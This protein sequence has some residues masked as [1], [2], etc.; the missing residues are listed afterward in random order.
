MLGEA[1]TG[2]VA[3]TCY[4]RDYDATLVGEGT[5]DGRA[6]WVLDLRAKSANVA[7][8]R[9]RY[10]IDKE[11]GLGINAEFFA[12]AGEVRKTARMEYD[13]H[14]RRNGRTVRFVSRVEI[15]DALQPSKRTVLKY[16]DV[17]VRDSAPPTLSL[18]P[19]DVRADVCAD[20]CADACADLALVAG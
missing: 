10:F 16:W 20:V 1:A 11:A 12:A 8:D 2:D 6:V 14:V 13:N 18:A 4:S 17:R 15:A 9:I 7:Y 3:T 5:V 19:G